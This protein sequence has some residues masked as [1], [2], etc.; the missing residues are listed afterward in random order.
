MNSGTVRVRLVFEEGRLLS[1]PQRRNGLKRSWILLKSHLHS[2]SDFSSYL[3]DLFLLRDACPHGL[4]LSMDG[5]V[6]PPFEPTSILKDGDIV[7][8]KKSEDNVIAV[9]TMADMEEGQ[10]AGLDVQ[11]LANEELVK[12]CTDY[13]NEAEQDDEHYDL[14]NQLEDTVDVGSKEKTVCRKRKALKTVHSSKKKKNRFA[15]TDKCLASPSN[16][17]QFHTDHNCRSQQEVSVSDKSLV[18]KRKSS[19]GNTGTNKKQKQV[20]Q[21]IVR[22]SNGKL[23]VE[24]YFEDSEQLDD[25][26]VDEGIVPVETRPGHVRFLPLDQ[27]EANQFVHPAQASMDTARSNG[28]TIKN[29]KKWGKGKSSFWRSNCN[30]EG[31]SSKSQAKKD[32]STRKCPI[33]FNELRPCLSLPE[34]GDIIAYRLIELSSSWTPE[35]S[36]FRVGK[37]SWCNPEANKIMLI[38][39]PEYP[40]VFK[41]MNEEAVK[42]PYAE[43]GSLKADYSSLVDIRIVEHENSLGFEAA[44]GG[45]ISEA[46]TSKQSWSKWEKHSIA[47][48]QSWNKWENQPRAPKQ[49]WKKWENDTSKQGENQPRASKQS[50]K[51]WENDTSKRENGKENAWDDIVQASSAKKANLSKDV[52]WG[53]GEK[54]SWKG[55]S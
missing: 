9:E 6:L 35:F 22:N 4:L 40:F 1:K 37:V 31:Q 14:L 50:W 54:K 47:P 10:P 17:Q 21:R 53:R 8:V 38:P 23:P 48:K 18:E 13:K 30:C 15:P 42:H 19:N 12:E 43:D 26:S 45:N 34:R 36:S 11:L 16:L 3:L 7:R 44:G 2:I 29:E 49:S 52:G 46:S 5:F 55:A 25:S 27:G 51:K 20:Q 41:A 39:V 33:D 24:N 32:S 28:I